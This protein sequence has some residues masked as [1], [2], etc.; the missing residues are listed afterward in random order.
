MG[1]SSSKSDASSSAVPPVRRRA[2]AR[3]RACSH[4][5]ARRR[6]ASVACVL[7]QPFLSSLAPAGPS[8]RLIGGLAPYLLLRP[9]FG[10]CVFSHTLFFPPFYYGLLAPSFSFPHTISDN[11]MLYRPS[12]TTHQ[13]P[14]NPPSHRTIS[15]VMRLI[16]NPPKRKMKNE[17]DK[18]SL[19]AHNNNERTNEQRTNERTNERKKKASPSKSKPPQ[20]SS[21]SPSNNKSS[22][23][24]E[25][26][27][28]NK[29]SS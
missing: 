12:H 15:A 23:D 27:R 26:T 7:S 11:I 24:N 17:M 18:Y 13:R 2:R 16:P 20:S 4:W 14:P 28:G 29:A 21:S 1:C 25:Y 10:L 19:R 8:V 22:F 9:I 6:A 3:A 5:C